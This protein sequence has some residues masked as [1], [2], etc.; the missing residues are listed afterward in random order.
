M[1]KT[2]AALLLSLLLAACS[3]IPQAPQRP[4]I[5]D[6]GAPPAPQSTTPQGAALSLWRVRAASALDSDAIL[7]RL[8]YDAEG[9]LQPRPYAHS[10]WSMSVPQL[11]DQ[12]ISARLAASR[13]VLDAA[14]DRPADLDLRLTLDECAQ[15]FTS[16]QDS[17]GVI[18]LRATLFNG[19]TQRLIAQR[20]FTASHPPPHPTPPAACKPCAQPQAT[21]LTSSTLGCAS[22]TPQKQNKSNDGYQQLAGFIS[23]QRK[24]NTIGICRAPFFYSLFARVLTV[25]RLMLPAMMR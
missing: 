10:R 18:R 3:A 13:P 21:S 25:C 24:T 9:D 7:Y 4:H 2:A 11:L 5:W 23:R 14:G 12:H 8:L 17:N 20:N 22:T 1:N 16:A 6:M 15:H 19:Q